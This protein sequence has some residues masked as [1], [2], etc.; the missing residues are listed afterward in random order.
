VSSEESEG[1]T[2]NERS[3]QLV[4]KLATVGIIAAALSQS[5]IAQDASQANRDAT[6][7][8]SSAVRI[9]Q[10]RAGQALADSYVTIR[11]EL[12]RP[13]PAGGDNNFVIRLDGL[14]PV[15][16]SDAEYTF[17]GMRSGQHIITVTEVDANGTPL[18]DARA[19]V[20][21]SVKPPE[22]SAPSTPGKGK[23]APGK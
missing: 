5:T 23:A 7:S 9:L 19:E 17:T 15:K 13:N 4:L 3:I 21:F 14:E 12:V 22:G 11:F 18:P 1:I 10:P 8:R 20:Q 6:Q 16:T 2:M